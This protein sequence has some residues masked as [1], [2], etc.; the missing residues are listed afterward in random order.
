VIGGV[1]A[2]IANEGRLLLAIP[3]KGGDCLVCLGDGEEWC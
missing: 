2:D 1:T 3:E